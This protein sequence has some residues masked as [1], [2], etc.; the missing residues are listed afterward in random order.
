MK[1]VQKAQLSCHD[2]HRG[3][4]ADR[5]HT[6]QARTPRHMPAHAGTWPRSV[7]PCNNAQVLPD[8]YLT[9]GKDPLPHLLCSPW[10]YLP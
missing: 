2:G 9:C 7:M 5:C 8:S 3:E 1:G 10:A 4:L 6:A